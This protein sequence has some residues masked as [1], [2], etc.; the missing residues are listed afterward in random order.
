M[1]G[2]GLIQNVFKSFSF[3]YSVVK[4]FSLKVSEEL[5]KLLSVVIEVKDLD[6]KNF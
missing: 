4:A 1:N 2:N 3:K 5:T 6:R